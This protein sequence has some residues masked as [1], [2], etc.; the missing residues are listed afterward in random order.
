MSGRNTRGNPEANKEDKDFDQSKIPR[1]LWAHNKPGEKDFNVKGTLRPGEETGAKSKAPLQPQKTQ[2]ETETPKVP[3]QAYSVFNPFG[4]LWNARQTREY[5]SDS[6]DE[7]E[8]FTS[9]KFHPQEEVV[10]ETEAE[11]WRGNTNWDGDGDQLMQTVNDITLG[12]GGLNLDDSTDNDVT[13]PLEITQ[14]Q[15]EAQQKETNDLRVQLQQLL[16]QQQQPNTTAVSDIKLEKFKGR[17]NTVS[18]ETWL[19]RA[20]DIA[21]TMEWTDL[22]FISSCTSALTDD[23]AEWYHIQKYD[24]NVRNAGILRDKA[25]FKR[26]F[27]EHF[28]LKKSVSA[29]IYTLETLK[30]GAKEVV[31]DFWVRVRIVCANMV[32]EHVA[33]E[34]LHP[35]GPCQQFPNGNADYVQRKHID[36]FMNRK[37][38]IILFMNGLKTPIAECIR[39]RVQELSEDGPEAVVKAAVEAEKSEMAKSKG[40]TAGQVFG[41]VAGIHTEVSEETQKA[42]IAAYERDRGFRG[43]GRGGRGGR[44]GGFQRPTGGGGGAGNSELTKLRGIQSRTRRRHCGACGQWGKHGT[45]ECRHTRAEINAM[46][47]MDPEKQPTGEIIDKCFDNRNTMPPIPSDSGNA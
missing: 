42:I 32:N 31:P 46:T 17:N 19:Q 1:E 4:G 43:R 37:L 26:T 36:R 27:L 33:E 3:P 10:P 44:G 11:Q 28:D 5:K 30:Q 45:H 9:P 23:A 35:V 41:E 12:A 2:E 20:E 40:A 18:A 34:Q 25:L 47:P 22:K 38:G 7:K 13:M 16:N 8:V 24:G 14:E 39:P 29:Q 6:E 15:W 21:A